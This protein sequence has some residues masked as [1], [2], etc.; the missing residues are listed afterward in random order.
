LVS[1]SEGLDE[2]SRNLFSKMVAAHTFCGHDLAGMV[3]EVPQHP[4]DE[5]RET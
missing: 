3:E 5:M 4:I 1:L 2:Y